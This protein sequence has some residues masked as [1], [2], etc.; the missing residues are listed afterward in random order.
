MGKKLLRSKVSRGASVAGIMSGSGVGE[1]RPEVAWR[2][3][4][5]ALGNE[6]AVRKDRK[7]QQERWL[8]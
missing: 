4:G 7:P 8:S 3:P 1:S 6:S 2:N 5:K